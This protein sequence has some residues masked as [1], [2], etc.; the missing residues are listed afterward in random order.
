MLYIL[1]IPRSCYMRRFSHPP[2]LHHSTN[3]YWNS[4]FSIFSRSP[5]TSSFLGPNILLSTLFFLNI[6]NTSHM[7]L[8]YKHVLYK[9]PTEFTVSFRHFP[10]TGSNKHIKFR[11][12]VLS[13][14]LHRR[15]GYI[16]CAPPY[17]KF[18]TK[19]GTCDFNRHPYWFLFLGRNYISASCDACKT[20]LN[21]C[22]AN[23]I[24]THK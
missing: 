20:H 14:S 21:N 7:S 2:W 12:L 3:I 9:C 23:R 16:L 15:Q 5:V 17:T 10:L 1:L 24:N 13:S 8:M 4:S 18:S 22:T 11:R 19:T 6:I